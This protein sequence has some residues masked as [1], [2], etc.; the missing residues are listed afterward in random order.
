MRGLRLRDAGV[1]LRI[2]VALLL[3]IIILGLV[4]PAFAPEDPR[5]WNTVPRNL[6]P[7]GDY[8]LGTTSQGQDV[9]WLLA[10]SVRNSLWVG[11]TVGVIATL[12]GAVVGMAAGYVGGLP[13]RVLTLLTDSFIVI[14]ALPILILFSALL[15][16]RASLLLVG[17]VLA[18]FNWPRPARQ[19]RAL[20]LSLRER[21]FMRTAWFAGSNTL[22]IIR[23]EIAPYLTGWFIANFVYTVLIAIATETGLAVIGLSNLQDTTLGGMIYWALRHQAILAE[24]WYWIGPPTLVIIVLSV[25]LFVVSSGLSKLSARRRGL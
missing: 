14:P 7:G 13:D 23:R 21:E 19:T 2:G 16:G 22:Q 17:C 11:F 8:L 6:A 18:V 12:F 5:R 1:E 15:E 24:R 25:A 4:V 10:L 3:A 20:V 9:F